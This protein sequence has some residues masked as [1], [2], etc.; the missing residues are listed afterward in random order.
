M[1]SEEQLAIDHIVNPFYLINSVSFDVFEIL[2]FSL[3]FNNLIIICLVG[4]YLGSSYLDSSRFLICRFC[5]QSRLTYP[6]LLFCQIFS[7][8]CM[9]VHLMMSYKLISLC[10]LFF[11]FL[12]SSNSVI[13][14]AWCSSL[15]VFSYACSN[16]LWSSS[17]YFVAVILA[18]EFIFAV[19]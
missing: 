3:S 6:H 9:I 10:S 16:L 19:L 1:V 11:T 14:P 15:L 18:T 17:E 4:V 2:L 13:S 7:I 5:P 12:W 8:I